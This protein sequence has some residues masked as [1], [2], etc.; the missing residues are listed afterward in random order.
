MSDSESNFKIRMQ[1]FKEKQLSTDYPRWRNVLSTVALT[2]LCLWM[3]GIIWYLY[4]TEEAFSCKKGFVYMSVVM[5]IFEMVLIM[6]MYN[7]K[8]IPR[9]ARDAM[10]AMICC[11]NIWFG[12][13]IFS[14]KA[15]NV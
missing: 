14:L 4:G 1:V 11:A 8:N 7:F 12:L 5:V 10:T 6:Y 3:V 13:F 15:C 2:T 9:F